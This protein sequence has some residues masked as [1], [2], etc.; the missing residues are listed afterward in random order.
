MMKAYTVKA[1]GIGLLLAAAACVHIA[2]SDAQRTDL[3]D[4]G[5][6]NWFRCSGALPV[7]AHF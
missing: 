2:V 7:S 3:Q 4:S 6:V 1:S 5:L